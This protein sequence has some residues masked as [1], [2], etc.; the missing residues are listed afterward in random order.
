MFP[1]HRRLNLMQTR[2]QA[3]W[4]CQEIFV[5]SRMSRLAL[6]LTQPPI[7]WVPG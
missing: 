6:G 1:N 5:S 3:G 7:H 4:Q 2:Q